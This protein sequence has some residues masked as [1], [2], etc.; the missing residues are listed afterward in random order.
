MQETR[1][2][3]AKMLGEANRGARHPS[4]EEQQGSKDEGM[5]EG[6]CKNWWLSRLTRKSNCRGI[7]R[8]KDIGCQGGAEQFAAKRTHSRCCRRS[9]IILRSSLGTPARR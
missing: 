8:G 3:M 2:N 7:A 9:W 1:T 4:S 5:Q 6:H